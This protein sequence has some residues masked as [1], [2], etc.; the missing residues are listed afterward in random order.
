MQA[1][2][3]SHDADQRHGR[4]V[5]AFGDHLRA[6]QHVAAFAEFVEQP[7][8]IAHPRRRVGIHAHHA[9]IG[10]EARHFFYH[11]FGADAEFANRL[12]PALRDRPFGNGI[13]KS[14]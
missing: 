5:E 11:A 3:G 9:R 14:Q 7:R 13:W 4:K 8:V 1:D 6:H 10:K 12:E 2:V